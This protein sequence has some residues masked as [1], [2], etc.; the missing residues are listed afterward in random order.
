M[1]VN[2]QNNQRIAK[3][4]ML[5]YIR[6]LILMFVNLYT[7]RVILKALGIEDY[8]IYN[9][10]GGFVAMFGMISTALGGAKSLSHIFIGKRYPRKIP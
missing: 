5:L 3:N 4:T 8:G 6:M 9:A 7:S 10:V 1:P 2:S